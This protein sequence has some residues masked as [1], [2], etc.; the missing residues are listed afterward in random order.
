MDNL[1]INF[2]CTACRRPKVFERTLQSFVEN[3]KGID[4]TQQT[5][6]INVDPVGEGAEYPDMVDVATRVFGMTWF[7]NAET[8]SFPAAVKWCFRQPTTKLFFHLEDDWELTEPFDIRVLVEEL[9]RSRVRPSGLHS[10]LT[11]DEKPIIDVQ[12]F[13][14]TCVNLRAYQWPEED[15]RLCLS[16]GLWRTAD[17]RVI[18]ERLSLTANP[19]KQ[20]R[21]VS[22]FNPEGGKHGNFWGKCIPERVVLCDIGREWLDQSGW[23]KETPIYFTKWEKA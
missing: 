19:E 10:R 22:P 21:A 12:R 16:P 6:H 9:E 1:Q 23:R 13:K 3:L 18:A 5:I 20:L 2:T 8:P 11:V 7:R 4:L 14:L 17:A 15:A